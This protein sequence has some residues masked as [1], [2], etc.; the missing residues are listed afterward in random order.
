MVLKRYLVTLDATF[1]TSSSVA[2]GHLDGDVPAEYIFSPGKN[3]KIEKAKAIAALGIL[4]GDYG[5]NIGTKGN[6]FYLP[7]PYWAGF[8]GYFI[9]R[10][11]AAGL[12][13]KRVKYIVPKPKK[14]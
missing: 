2:V 4:L 6:D 1:L 11:I 9:I 5:L 8:K 13:L 14:Q 12:T 7:S 10:D 3:I